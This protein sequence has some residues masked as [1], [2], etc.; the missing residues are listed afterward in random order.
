MG[1]HE[2]SATLKASRGRGNHVGNHVVRIL[3]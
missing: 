3:R 2:A 1:E